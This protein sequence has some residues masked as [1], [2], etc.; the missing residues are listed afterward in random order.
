MDLCVLD[1]D[2]EVRMHNNIRTD[3]EAFLLAV[4]P[5]REDVVVCVECMFTWYWLADLC[6]D[7]AIPFVL[8]HALSMRAIHGGQAKNDRIDSH[9]I[10]ALL[11]GG[12]IPRA[13]V[14]PRRMRATRDLLRRRN[15]LM[16]K[17]AELYAH[18]QNTASHYNLG[19][20]VGRIA[21]PQ[22]RRG[23]LERFDHGG[24]QQNMALDLALVDFYDPL[25]AEVEHYIEKTARGHD[26]VSLA[27]LRTI[28]GVGN[29][30][31]LVML[32]EIEDITRFPRVQAFVSYCRLVKSARE[33][34]G[35]RHG[36]R[37][38]KIGN[39]HLKWAFSEAAVL[40]LKHN[41]LA[42]KDLAKL[43]NRHGKG[44]ALSSLAHKLGRAVYS[45][46]KNQVAFDR[47]KFLAV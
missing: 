32:Y 20:P 43:A 31:A 14:Y 15:H 5:S 38:K 42:K 47:A 29:I 23:L 17:R 22:N 40:F 10:A 18:I 44:K 19:D 26:P 24:V 3:P 28:P 37:G 4:K 25:L 6:E 30:L 36:P 21:K 1:A 11:R 45:R 12:L 27:L 2:G 46:L 39:A 33:S 16:P 35:K 41:E 9:K 13:Y 34:N 7:E 8:G